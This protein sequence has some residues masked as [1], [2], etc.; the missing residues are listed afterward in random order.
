MNNSKNSNENGDNV[1]SVREPDPFST[2]AYLQSLNEK[3]YKAYL[4][5]RS[6]L[7][8]SFQLEKSNGYLEWRKEQK[9]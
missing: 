9:S 1:T 5:A 3:E 2:D 4:I 8:T 6:H 7:G